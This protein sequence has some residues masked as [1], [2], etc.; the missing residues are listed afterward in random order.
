M[1]ATLLLKGT[2]K[3]TKRRPRKVVQQVKLVTQSPSVPARKKRNRRRRRQRNAGVVNRRMPRLSHCALQYAVAIADPWSEMAIGV[4]VPIPAGLTQKVRGYLRIQQTTTATCFVVAAPCLANNLPQIF[5]STGAYANNGIIAIETAGGFNPNIGLGILTGLPY[6]SANFLPADAVIPSVAGRVVSAG[7]TLRYAGKTINT[8][9]IAYGYRHP[10]H[11]SVA[12][13]ATGAPGSINYWSSQPECYDCSF[14]RQT[15]YSSDWAYTRREMEICSFVRNLNDSISPDS[16]ATRTVYPFCN[17]EFDYPDYANP[18]V[19][20]NVTV[21]G[22]KVG[23]PTFGFQF[24]A[25]AGESYFVEYV[26]HV[27]YNGP[28]TAS[29]GSLNPVD[30]RGAEMVSQAANDAAVSQQNQTPQST[31]QTIVEKVGELTEA[32]TEVG[33]P[34]KAMAGQVLYA[35]ARLARG[36]ATSRYA[37][38]GALSYTD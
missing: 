13:D 1:S 33:I 7:L 35:G 2:P 22:V 8:A 21:S 38:R 5:Y 16:A 27:E 3:R 30:A 11:S 18:G 14:D 19:F 4:C 37:Q 34:I 23:V 28:Q 6:S 20:T 26:I 15:I 9:G 32:A 31:F 25:T 36:Y 10:T 24:T 17:G 29:L 12:S